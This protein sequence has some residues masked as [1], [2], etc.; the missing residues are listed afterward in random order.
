MPFVG[1]AF[2]ADI[3]ISVFLEIQRLKLFELNRSLLKC[4]I[5]VEYLLIVV[6]IVRAFRRL[7]QTKL[8]LVIHCKI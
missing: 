6:N 3:F 8:F 2:S 1:R 5:Y 7:T 4:L